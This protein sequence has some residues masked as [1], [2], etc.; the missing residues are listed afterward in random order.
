MGIVELL[1]PRNPILED[2][3]AI[4]CNDGSTHLTTVRTGTPVAH[5]RRLNYGVPN[6]K[7]RTA[8]VRDACGMLEVYSTVDEK[9]IQI[10]GNTHAFRLSEATAFVQG[11]SKQMAETL[12]YGNVSTHP[13]RFEGIASRYDDKDADSAENIV[14]GDGSSNL[15]SIYLVEW[16]PNS[17]H[18][19][20]PKGTT[21]GIRHH[22]RGI[23]DEE[24]GNGGRYRAYRDHW[25]WDNGLT[26]RDWRTCGRIA[27]IDVTNL[28]GNTP[29][30][31]IV[32]MIQLSEQV[33]TN[34]G[35]KAFYVPK[36]IAT[37]LR[38][39]ILN[40]K[41][42][43]LTFETVEGKKVMMFDGIPVRRVDAI[44]VNETKVNL[45]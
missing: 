26:I 22:D 36:K 21:A 37:A 42:V 35:R 15:T 4:E 10:N 9:L 17:A 1:K 32:K 34:G 7:S 30:D 24:D 25:Q 16:G 28:S 40:H 3:T 41:N 29:T 12:I 23:V 19:I 6:S 43:N 38:I 2:A 11:L 14:D 13:E 18:M 39:Q 44:S 33:E 45:S 8:Q 20:Y 27:N 31:L 5:W